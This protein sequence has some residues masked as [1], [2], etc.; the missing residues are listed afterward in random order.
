MKT[1]NY[2]IM[3]ES[4]EIDKLQK[5]KDGYKNIQ[6]C[7]EIGYDY[8]EDDNF[9]TLLVIAYG[10]SLINGIYSSVE[11]IEVFNDL[12]Q[13]KDEIYVSERTNGLS[14][15]VHNKVIDDTKDLINQSLHEMLEH[16]CKNF[17]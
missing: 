2:E 12:K 10:G 15:I 8:N 5:M 13:V 6:S 4:F 11:R 14:D 1:F 3:M 9:Y 7:F 17:I 16:L